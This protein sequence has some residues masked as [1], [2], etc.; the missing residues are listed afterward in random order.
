MKSD[1]E[2]H[3]EEDPLKTTIQTYDHS[4]ELYANNIWDMRLDRILDA[5]VNCLGQGARVLDLGCGPGRDTQH[6]QARGLRAFG[7]D[8]SIGMLQEAKRRVTWEFVQGDMRKLPL[9]TDQL[10][11]IWLSAA[12]IH[13]PRADVPKALEEVRRVLK[14]GGVLFLGVKRG[15]GESWRDSKLGRRF[16]IFYRLD[17]IIDLV[18]AAKFRVVEE[19]ESQGS[20]D[21]WISIVAEAI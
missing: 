2:F 17:E 21:V 15:Q 16:F 14:P 5:F 8:L 11:G 3:A 1:R 20:I 12:L 7:I 4:A 6:L 18:H 13:L 10:D 9:N 19:W